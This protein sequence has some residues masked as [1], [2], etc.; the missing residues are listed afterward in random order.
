MKQALL[1]MLIG[2][3]GIDAQCIDDVRSK[4]NQVT[5]DWEEMEM[6][7]KNRAETLKLALMEAESFD[8]QVHELLNWLPSI[9]SRLQMRGLSGEEEAA[10]LEQMDEVAQIRKELDDR[11]PQLENA[12]KTGRDIQNAC[13]QAAVQ[14]MKYWLKILQTRWDEV[15]CAVDSKRESLEKQLN[16]FHEQEE[17]ILR[18]LEYVSKKNDEIKL[19][20]E[21]ALPR[22]LEAI[23]KLIDAHDVFEREVRERQPEID[24]ACRQRKPPTFVNCAVEK[25]AKKPQS[26]RVKPVRNPKSDQLSERWK[27][28]WIDSM[29]YGRKLNEMRDYLVEVKKLESFTFEDW[30]ERYL[31]W[32]DAG[33]ARIS[34]LFRR[35][36]KSGLGRVPRT[37]FIDGIISSKFPTSR[38]EMEKVA[39]VFDKGDKMIDAK[40]FMAKLR[41][42]YMKKLP[43]KPKTDMEKINEEVARQSERCK[44]VTPYKI[45]KVGEGHYRF[46]DTQIKRM[47]RILRST[48]MVRV[49]GG[50]AALDEFL[51]K[52]DPCR[53]KGRTNIDIQRGFH[54]DIHDEVR[55]ETFIL[56]PRVTPS[57]EVT[58][59]SS[60]T[61]PSSRYVATPGPITKIRE[62]TERS[63]PMHSARATTIPFRTS[64]S[65]LFDSSRRGSE[66]STRSNESHIVRPANSGNISRSN[67]RSE[68]KE[69]SR[70]GSRCSVASESS[71]RPTRIPSIRG[72]KRVG[73]LP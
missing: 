58:L 46:G 25:G 39:D 12:L 18:L 65:N 50:W 38:L 32:T 24:T 16:D 60:S 56:S 14:P 2:Q 27:K 8:E 71:E 22:D 53:A 70:P 20:S 41:S 23:E 34:D 62:K 26:K 7:V 35:I 55:M 13:S 51:H 61:F 33:K 17:L 6:L 31:E 10:L 1:Q 67:S 45:Q 40:E 44:C 57:R 37:A 59:P 48:V 68:L 63:L 43:P 19:A 52:H 72:R 11:V 4:L 21:D 5:A 64:P 28:L 30:R 47:V 42:D 3:V 29:D 49:G 36:D 69:G 66:A 54:D 9:E 73:H 15:S